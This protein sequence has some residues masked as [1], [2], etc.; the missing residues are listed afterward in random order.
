M[1][2]FLCFLSF[3]RLSCLLCECVMSLCLAFAVIVAF[4]VF[5]VLFVVIGVFVVF[6]F[7]F[8]V[9]RWCRS[10]RC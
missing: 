4:V 9:V 10:I 7:F 6:G 8:F 3:L 5:V 2:S 1:L